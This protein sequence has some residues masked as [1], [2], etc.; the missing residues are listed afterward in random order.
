MAQA[1]LPLGPFEPA[2]PMM[3]EISVVEKNAVWCFWQ[4]LIGESQH[5]PGGSGPGPCHL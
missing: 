3:L 2:D 4:A 1:A 5:K